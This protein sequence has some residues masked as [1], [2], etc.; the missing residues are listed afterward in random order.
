M[1]II[2]ILKYSF[3]ILGLGML[4]SA[5][6]LYQNTQQFLYDAYLAKGIVVSFEESSTTSGVTFHPVVQYEDTKGRNI[7]FISSSGSNPPTYVQGEEVE[8][9]YVP[10]PQREAQINHFF[11]LWGAVLILAGL[12]ATFFLAG[13]G[14]M[15]YKVM[16]DRNTEYLKLNG[17]PVNAQFISV[18]L[19]D[20]LEVNG[21][22]PFRIQAMWQD[23]NTKQVHHF[24]SDYIWFDPSRYVREHVTVM[25]DQSNPKKYHMDLT[26]LPSQIPE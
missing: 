12:G 10:G 26:F 7:E 21:K 16:K 2:L 24:N 23:P 4:T 22:H 5:G 9:L 8:V 18:E 19:N 1:K 20:A 3:F 17:M 6:L 13:S 14:M 25:I 11:S 15:V